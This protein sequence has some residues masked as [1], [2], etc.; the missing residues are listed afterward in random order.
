MSFYV[1]IVFCPVG[2]ERAR[3]VEDPFMMPYRVGEPCR[4]LS[5]VRKEVWLE[6]PAGARI[7]RRKNENKITKF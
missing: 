3:M 2:L 5:R 7:G 1:K 4:M 6:P